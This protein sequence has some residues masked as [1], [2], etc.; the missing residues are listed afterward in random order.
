MSDITKKA[1]VDSLKELLLRKP[2]EKITIS[3]IAND[4]GINRMTFYYHFRD[5]YDCLTWAAEDQAREALEGYRSYSTWDEGF[6]HVFRTARENRPYIIAIYRSLSREMLE[7][8]LYSIT[9][10]L[11]G[12]VVRE[13][14]GGMSVS[15]NDL[16][17]IINFYK[18]SFVGI[19][20]DWVAG[21][22]EKDP[23]EIVAQLKIMLRGS[24]HGALSRFEENGSHM[25]KLI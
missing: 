8:Y 18:Y 5:I 21:G 12:P 6:L 25:K 24:I 7:R 22:M 19:L 4:C 16:S 3:D 14:A 17:F 10:E 9:S 2:L 1:I 11:V 13:E 15:E 23:E 20:L